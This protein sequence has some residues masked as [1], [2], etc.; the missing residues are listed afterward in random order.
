[1]T[2]CAVICVPDAE[3]GQIV[4]AMVVLRSGYR[5]DKAM[6]K[7]LQDSVNPRAVEFRRRCRG[8]RPEAAE[9]QVAR[10]S[11]LRGYPL[12]ARG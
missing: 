7:T 6:V 1:M 2:D 12:S 5:A 11:F 4:K 8:R 10:V 9:V 3:R